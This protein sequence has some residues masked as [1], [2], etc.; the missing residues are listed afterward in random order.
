MTARRVS[1]R[2]PRATRAAHGVPAEPRRFNARWVVAVLLCTHYALGLTSVW[3]KSCSCDEIA[4][5][6]A[7]YTYWQTGDYRLVPEHPPLIELWASLPLNFMSLKLPS[8]DQPAWHNSNQWQ[9]GWQF[10]YE[11]GNPLDRMLL[12]GR[13]M[14]GLFSVG[15]GL[16]IYLVARRWFGVAG[17]LIAL[18]LFTFSP[19]MLAHGFQITTDM[20]A[21]LFF[22]LSL[23]SIWWALHRVSIASVLFSGV[24]LAALFNAKLS[25]VLVIPCYGVLL[26]ARCISNRPLDVAFG[27]SVAIAPR[28]RRL[29]VHAAVFAAQV[30]IVTGGIWLAHG[31]KYPAFVNARPGVDRWMSTN[32]EPESRQPEW[33]FELNRAGWVAPAVSF[34]RDH[35]L[36][37][38]AYLYGF[39]YAKNMTKGSVAFLNGERRRTGFRSYFPY[40]FLIKTTLPFLAVLLLSLVTRLRRRSDQPV[41][42]ATTAPNTPTWYRALPLIIFF[43]LYWATAIAS[44]FNIGH[45]HILPI[46]PPLMIACGALATV[47]WRK[48][49]VVTITAAILALHAGAALW[50]WPNYLSFF[51]SFVGRNGYRHLVDSSVDWGQDLRGLADW[52]ND[53]NPP[54]SP[55]AQPVY[56]SYLGNGNPE[57]YGIRPRYLPSNSWWQTGD[58][59][60]FEPGIYCISATLLQQV[61]LL[62]VSRWT[63]ELESLYQAALPRIEQLQRHDFASPADAKGLPDEIVRRIRFG[64]LCAFLREREPDADVGRSILIYYLTPSDLERALT[65]PPPPMVVDSA[66]DLAAIGEELAVA[67]MTDRPAELYRRALEGRPDDDHFHKNLGLLLKRQS[68]FADAAA[69]FETVIRLNPQSAEGHHNLAAMYVRL[70][71]TSDSIRHYEEAIRLRRNWP[72]AHAN[73]AA[74]LLQLGRLDEAI[75]EYEKALQLQP[76]LQMAKEGLRQALER[77]ERKS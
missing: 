34:A 64:R 15:L 69:E 19:E 46:Y 22:L 58:Y 52:L 62:P 20:A 23:L 18:A 9:F 43:I 33:D 21:T 25:A 71:R 57:F 2:P 31:L 10:F 47:Q 4:Y 35:R 55:G 70:G 38:E 54:Q 32:T 29:A 1:S 12:A 5:L 68:R 6:T 41:Q 76:D 48:R 60:A 3:R 7:G 53:H 11:L 14:I 42:N 28:L 63:P 73:L 72:E 39:L 17:G 27:R 56:L 61:Y 75:R 45:R 26:L 65:G 59:P 44:P 66:D 74:A 8:L 24:A 37:P 40:T 67:G 16:T 36:L 51:N 49:P 50:A 77:L 30:L 13:A